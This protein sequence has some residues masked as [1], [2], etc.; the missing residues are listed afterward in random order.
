MIY[1]MSCDMDEAEK[2]QVQRMQRACKD[3][4]I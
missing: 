4:R 2:G 3:G 1:V